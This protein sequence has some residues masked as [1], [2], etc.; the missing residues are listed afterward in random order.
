MHSYISLLRGINVSGKN[1]I[2]MADLRSLYE[3][4]GFQEVETY[5]QSGNVLFKAKQTDIL[6]IQDLI[7]S[8]IQTKYGYDISIL[9][10]KA[11]FINTVVEKNP[12]LQDRNEDIKFLHVTF[13]S[14]IPSNDLV[15]QLK[16]LN[17]KEDEFMIIEKL[18][19]LFTPGG[20]GK[21]K[22]S[23]NFLERKLK[24]SATTRNWKTIS[25]LQNMISNS[26]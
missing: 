22:L 6:T 15:E 20:Y 4:L 14:Q 3:S 26:E 5:I 7:K 9:V 16:T 25:K 11:N 17:Y 19:F 12:F 13:L 10:L 8:Q 23:N 1:K 2:K 24:T 21:T 18:V